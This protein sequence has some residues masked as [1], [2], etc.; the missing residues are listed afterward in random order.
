MKTLKTMKTIKTII[1]GI[2]TI[3]LISF[4]TAQYSATNPWHPLIQISGDNGISSVDADE[5]GIIDKANASK[6]CDSDGVCEVQTLK[7]E[8]NIEIANGSYLYVAGTTT[9]LRIGDD[10]D[11]YFNLNQMYLLPVQP[12]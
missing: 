6:S 3:L 7:S 5:D 2:I 12:F 9:T 8:G 11:L 1:Y 4:A 10:D